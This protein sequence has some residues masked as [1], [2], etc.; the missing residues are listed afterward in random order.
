MHR[1]LIAPFV[2]LALAACAPVELRVGKADGVPA[3]AGT[4]DVTL[5]MFTCGNDIPAGDYTV[6]TKKVTGGCELSFDKDVTVLKSTD[7]NRLP[8]LM[9]AGNLVQA[10]ELEITV[11]KFTDTS[12]GGGVVLDPSTRITS[13]TFALNGQLL[14]TDKNALKTLPKTVSLTGTAL[15]SLK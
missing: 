14:V 3:V 4:V 10:I 12:N 9:G 8:A 1:F 7:Y 11:L 6:K 13:A 15:D 5:D 2:V